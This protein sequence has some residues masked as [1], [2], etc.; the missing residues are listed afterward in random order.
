[1]T[2]Q[3]P[4]EAEH[5]GWHSISWKLSKASNQG[6]A[7]FSNQTA[8]PKNPG[9]QLWRKGTG[10]DYWFPV[11]GEVTF[12]WKDEVYVYHLGKASTSVNALQAANVAAFG[13]WEVV[14]ERNGDGTYL[15][16][17]LVEAIPRKG[18]KPVPEDR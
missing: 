18:G 13:T 14:L 5:L 12:R 3:D 2:S 8:I 11:S 15:G 10:P 1:L 7:A 4:I 9:K 16:S 17:V 6:G